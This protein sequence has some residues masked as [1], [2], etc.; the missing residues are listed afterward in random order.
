MSTDQNI[1]RRMK[2]IGSAF[3]LA[4]IFVVMPSCTVS[5]APRLITQETARPPWQVLLK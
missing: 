1:A 5:K 2:N 3:L 4:S